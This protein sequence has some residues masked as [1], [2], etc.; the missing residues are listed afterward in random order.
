MRSG[1]L[2]GTDFVVYQM[3]PGVMHSEYG[4]MVV[5]LATPHDPQM[6]WHDVQITNR[7]INQVR[8][9]QGCLV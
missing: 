8:A 3:H 9:E 2:Y 5:P 6:G 4:I 1:L 7:L